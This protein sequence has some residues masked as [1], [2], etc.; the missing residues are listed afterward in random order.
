MQTIKLK[1]LGRKI[2]NNKLHHRYKDPFTDNVFE[3]NKRLG[4]GTIGNIIQAIIVS[5]TDGLT[6]K[7]PYTVV[8]HDEQDYDDLK[9]KDAMAYKE[10]MLLKNLTKTK[11]TRI[12]YLLD[13]LWAEARKLPR[14]QRELFIAKIINKVL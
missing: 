3:Y 9:L 13:E 14:N 10:F 6:L 1:Y 5:D 7:G 4:A 2:S 11:S 8:S 12:D